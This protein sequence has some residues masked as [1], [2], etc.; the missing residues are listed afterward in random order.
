MEQQKHPQKPPPTQAQTGQAK[1]AFDCD[2]LQIG[3]WEYAKRRLVFTSYFAEYKKG[4][5]IFGRREAKIILGDSDSIQHRIDIPYHDCR[6]IILGTSTEPTVSF[7]LHMAP[8][9]YELDPLESQDEI[10]AILGLMGAATLNQNVAQP[11]PRQAG[12][13]YRVAAINPRHAQVVGHCFVYRIALLDRSKLARIRDIISS[14][15]CT[16]HPHKT[17]VS[18]PKEPMEKAFT[19]LNHELSDQ[20]RFGSRPFQLL[21][22]VDRLARNGYLP[23]DKVIQML[24]HISRIFET[25]GLDQ[26]VAALRMLSR[27][28]PL[29]GPDTQAQDFSIG[30]LEEALEEYVLYYDGKQWIVQ[31]LTVFKPA[32]ATNSETDMQRYAAIFQRYLLTFYLL[33]CRQRPRQPVRAI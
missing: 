3:N 29:P 18:E 27:N 32:G 24:P 14:E 9:L 8:K 22:Q 6:D 7:T 23:P 21:Y 25:Y 10:S 19:R 11:D 5:V 15:K 20:G 16:V 30:A 31:R 1:N 26:T 33:L 17:A 4:R 28:L 12:K 2:I 13:K